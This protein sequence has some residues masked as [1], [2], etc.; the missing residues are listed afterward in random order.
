MSSCC[1]VSGSC[2]K[3][4]TSTISAGSGIPEVI[5]ITVRVRVHRGAASC[6]AR[7]IAPSSPMTLRPATSASS[8]SLLRER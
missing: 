3:P 4:S 6:G 1:G 7:V 8:T 5:V 2:L